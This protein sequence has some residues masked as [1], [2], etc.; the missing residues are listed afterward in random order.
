MRLRAAG[1]D[2]RKLD[3]DIDLHHDEYHKTLT[4]NQQEAASLGLRGTPA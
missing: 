3:A 2:A 4:R 1:F